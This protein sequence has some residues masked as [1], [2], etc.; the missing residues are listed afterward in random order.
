MVRHV[1]E[2]PWEELTR[3][4]LPDDEKEI[5]ER[6]IF[7]WRRAYAPWSGYRFGS[8]VLCKD[9]SIYGG[10]NIEN[11]CLS[12]TAHSEEVA[13]YHADTEGKGDQIIKLACIGEQ[14]GDK[15]WAPCGHCLVRM[16]QYEHRARQPMVV[17]FGGGT[18]AR[19]VGVKTLM[20]MS[21]IPSDLGDVEK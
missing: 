13:C 2:V 12:P 10:H 16:A 19:V 14:E 21:F 6:A 5:V 17:L 3:Q 8:S 11:Y 4:E 18:V 20:P 1:I 15:Y 7:A 9:G